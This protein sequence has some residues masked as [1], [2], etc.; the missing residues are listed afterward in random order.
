MVLSTDTLF[1]KKNVFEVVGLVLYGVQGLHSF[2]RLKDECLPEE[3]GS[4]SKR[5]SFWHGDVGLVKNQSL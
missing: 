4:C 1:F 2:L 3:V 5:F